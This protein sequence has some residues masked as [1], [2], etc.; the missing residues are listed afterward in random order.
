MIKEV[1]DKISILNGSDD[2]TLPSFV[3]GCSGAIL[4]LGNIAPKICIDIYESVQ[5][6]D[7]VRARELYFKMLPLAQAIGSPENFPAPIKEALKILGKPAGPCRSPVVS[8]DSKERD[9]IRG[10]LERAG[11]TI[12]PGVPQ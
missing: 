2:L 5:I 9:Q 1:G 8:V 3:L 10:A 7:I 6:G 11:L 12:L 4:A